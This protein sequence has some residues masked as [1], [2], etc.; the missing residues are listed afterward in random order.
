MKRIQHHLST[1][2]PYSQGCYISSRSKATWCP[3]TP[4]TSYSSFHR[5]SSSARRTAAFWGPVTI[6]TFSPA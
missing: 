5:R 1:S 4:G 2:R 3:H 6:L